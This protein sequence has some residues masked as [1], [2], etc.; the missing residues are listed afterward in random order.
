MTNK[1]HFWLAVNAYHEARGEGFE[2]MVAVCHVVLNRT[3]KNKMSVRDVILQ[4]KQFSWTNGG[5]RPPIGDYPALEMAM[6]AATEADQKQRVGKDLLGADH[7]YAFKG[8]N[9]IP[10]PS[11]VE[12]GNMVEVTRIGNH[13][14]FRS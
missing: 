7:Y 5:K 10:E 12:K 6:D 2:G 14:F 4:P 9:A 8:P 11:W 3:K 13:V 1:D